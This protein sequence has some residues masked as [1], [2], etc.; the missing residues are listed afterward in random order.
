MIKIVKGD[1]LQAEEDIIGHRV[2]CEFTMDSGIAERIKNKYPDV[3]AGYK[4]L[5]ANYKNNVW[6][7]GKV[8]IS[9]SEDGKTIA[10]L[11]IQES[12]GYD[13]NQ[14]TE[15]KSLKEALVRV[16]DIAK[17]NELSIA[18]PLYIGGSD[19]TKTVFIASKIFED[20]EVTFYLE[21]E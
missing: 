9:D 3:Y 4:S 1:L 18:L 12:K 7:M 11:F 17:K 20:Y 16:K 6:I 5:E 10:N 8:H 13:G 14:Y 2:N 19:V 21:D 15:I